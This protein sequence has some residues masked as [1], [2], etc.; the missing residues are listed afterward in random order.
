MRVESG[1]GE[2]VLGMAAQVCSSKGTCCFKVPEDTTAARFCPEQRAPQA[3]QSHLR[4]SWG[5]HSTD[6]HGRQRRR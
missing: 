1:N 4:G 3:L 6:H 2:K 5:L